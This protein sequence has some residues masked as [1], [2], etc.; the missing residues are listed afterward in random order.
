MLN[1]HTVD[2]VFKRIGSFPDEFVH[3]I[4]NVQYIYFTKYK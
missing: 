1:I 4:L 2:L 3:A